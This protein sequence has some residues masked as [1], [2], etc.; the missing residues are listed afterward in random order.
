MRVK[1]AFMMRVF[2]AGESNTE[3]ALEIL[4]A[5]RAEC[6]GKLEGMTAAHDIIAGYAGKVGHDTGKIRGWKIAALYCEEYYRAGLTWADKA[7]AIL[8]EETRR[9]GCDI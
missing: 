6:A 9:K 8:E 1:S 4:R 2:F 3:R 5:Y 7:I